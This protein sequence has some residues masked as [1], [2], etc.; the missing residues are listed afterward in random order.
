MP[1]TTNDDVIE[2]LG[3]DYDTVN[4]PSLEPYIRAAGLIVDRVYTCSV[5][6][7]KTL[8]T[9]EL[10]ELETWLAAHLYVQSDQNLSSKSTLGASGQ[11]Q[12]RTEKRLEASKYGQ[13]CIGIDYSGCLLN[14]FERN[15][16]GLDWLGLPDSDQLDYWERN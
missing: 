12:G 16:G 10:F 14:Q 5:R 8:T 6:K 7:D 1:R 2:V 13:S 9:D 11:F 15:V 3:R 4:T